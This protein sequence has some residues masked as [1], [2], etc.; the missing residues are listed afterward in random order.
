MENN[1]T[2]NDF[3]L[4]KA[5]EWAETEMNLW[6]PNPDHFIIT[7]L[8]LRN[9]KYDTHLSLFRGTDNIPGI[10]RV[11]WIADNIVKYS[12]VDNYNELKTSHPE[13]VKLLEQNGIYAYEHRN[14]LYPTKKTRGIVIN[15]QN[16]NNSD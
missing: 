5:Y 13:I 2:L 7:D 10:V 15:I 11:F 9:E 1:Y 6:F 3:K 4:Q 14:D 8:E 16:S 12:I